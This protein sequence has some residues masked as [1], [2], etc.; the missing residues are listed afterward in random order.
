MNNIV[1]RQTKHTYACICR[2]VAL[3]V[4]GVIMKIEKISAT[5]VRRQTL[6]LLLPKDYTI[7]H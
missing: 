6:L 5:V 3:K 1:Y 4:S 7:I 2:P